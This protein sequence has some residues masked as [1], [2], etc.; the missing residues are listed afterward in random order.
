MGFVALKHVLLFPWGTHAPR[1]CHP[2]E[3]CVLTRLKLYP[4]CLAKPP[5]ESTFRFYLMYTSET[6]WKR[7]SP[8]WSCKCLAGQASQMHG[9]PS[10][11]ILCSCL[12]TCRWVKLELAK[13]EKMIM[14]VTLNVPKILGH[15]DAMIYLSW[16]LL[17]YFT[18]SPS[19]WQYQKMINL[20]LKKIN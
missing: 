19:I 16:L 7:P 1:A 5:D 13:M 3:W 20:R 15:V 2:P 8:H 17:Q 18:V 9:S 4:F 10:L 14:Q 11:E 6:C 12:Q